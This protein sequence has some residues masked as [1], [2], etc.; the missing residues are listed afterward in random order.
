MSIIGPN[1]APATGQPAGTKIVTTLGPASRSLDVL[2][3]LLRSGADVVRIN[4]SHGDRDT[5]AQLVDVCRQAA[6]TIKR[7]VAIMGDLCGPKIRIQRLPD[8]PVTFQV[9]QTLTLVREPTDGTRRTL[10]TNQPRIID[11]LDLGDRVLIDDGQVRFRVVEKCSDRI[12][13]A[14]VVPGPVGSNKGVNLPDSDLAI[15]TLTDKDLDDLRWSVKLGLDFVALSFVRSAADVRAL[16]ARLTRLGGDAQIVSKIETP[17]AIQDIDAIIDSSDAV[18][19]AR[20]DLGVE[21]ETERVPLIQ[22]QITARCRDVGKPVIIATQM[23][24]SM[25]HSP[26]PTRAEVSD[27]ANAILDCTDAVMLSAETAVGQYPV[28]A[29]ETMHRIAVQTEQYDQK[30]QGSLAVN[31]GLS[32]VTPCVAQGIGLLADRAGAK[33]VALWTEHGNIARMV[34]KHRLDLPVIALTASTA[35]QRRMA[36]LYG[37]NAVQADK[38]ADL[39]ARIVQADRILLERGFAA[40]GDLVIIGFG[41]KTLEGG[42]TGSVSIHV[43]DAGCTAQPVT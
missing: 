28:A 30:Q 20:G 9:D 10:A 40:D 14:C 29:V 15:D 12:V 34:S 42:A 36:L 31:T 4:F 35:A 6:Q 18:L 21:V 3:R 11:D 33:A 24:Q 26:V 25:V 1:H 7:P 5:H 2:T 43:V 27:V 22:K 38:P 23:L 32:G 41:A 13:C 37:V 8:G 19:V 16:R 17:Q 39:T